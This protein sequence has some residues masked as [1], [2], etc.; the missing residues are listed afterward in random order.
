MGNRNKP[1]NSWLDCPG[2]ALIVQIGS[3]YFFAAL[4]KTGQEWR[5]GSATYYS[6]MVDQLTTPLAPWLL[7]RPALMK[8]LT[9][10]VLYFEYAVGFLLLGPAPVRWAACLGISAMHLGFGMCMHLGVFALV[11][12]ASPIGLWPGLVMEKVEKSLLFQKLSRA[13]QSRLSATAG[14]EKSGLATGNLMRAIVMCLAGLTV[15]WNLANLPGRRLPPGYPRPLM[16]LLG[17]NQKW[18]M[19]APRPLADDGWYVIDGTLLNGR[20]V[21]LFRNGA[22]VSWSKPARVASTYRNARWRKF[23]MN[24]WSQNHTV[25]RLPF[26]RY[27]TRQWNEAHSGQEQVAS[28]DICF[29]L[30][31]TLPDGT[32][33][34]VKK[35]VIWHHLCFDPK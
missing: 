22:E 10:V 17:L 9:F 20:H 34:P 16:M 13:C 3:V 14:P 26:G 28:F 6:L 35:I 12:M 18:D 7:A 27:L 31:N 25:S 2:F 24:L 11:G 1:P 15:G 19:F 8:A 4:L 29:M 33:A 23:M 32:T 30:E 21:D 5:D